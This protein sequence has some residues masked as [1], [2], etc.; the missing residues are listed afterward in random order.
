R[1]AGFELL[2]RAGEPLQLS[3]LAAELLGSHERRRVH[4]QPLVEAGHELRERLAA[5]LV[6]VHREHRLADEL[7][8]DVAFAS[9]LESFD[10]DLAEC[11]RG[12]RVQV[13]H[14][15]DGFGFRK[16]HGTLECRRGDGLRVA[17][18]QAH[19]NTGAL[20]DLRRAARL[21]RELR[22]DVLHIARE[23]DRNVG[24]DLMRF[25][26]D[27]LYFVADR[28]RVVRADL[29]AKAVLERRDDASAVRVVLGIGR[30][31]EEDVERQPHL[32]AADLDVALLEQVQQTDLDAFCEVGKL[33]DGKYAAVRPWDESVVDGELVGQIPALG[34][35][36]RVD[37]ADEVGDRDVGCRELL[38]VAVLGLQPHDRR[39]V[40][41]V[42]DEVTA[43]GADGLQRIVADLAT[44]DRGHLV[45]E[46]LDEVAHDA[47]LRLSA[48]AQKDDVVAGEDRVLDGG[49]DGVVVTDDS[50][51][52]GLPRPD[53]LQ[54]VFTQF[55]PDRA[56]L[57]AGRFQGSQGGRKRQTGSLL[58]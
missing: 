31:D 32:V 41:L 35:L 56:G 18:G 23:P 3:E 38:R 11:G 52:D 33:V 47:R 30:R 14:P 42:R 8:E 55:V 9:F 28:L 15:R 57:V 44:G 36:D 10:L 7:G 20:V 12:D 4:R 46:E 40:A 17:D 34:D 51:E 5:Q 43:R 58:S 19:R 45:V 6:L 1:F 16:T 37:L 48:L 39:L 53:L 29:R 2:Q 49:Y 54:E 27:D 24:L 50:L 13:V 25:E 22:N 21:V 26:L